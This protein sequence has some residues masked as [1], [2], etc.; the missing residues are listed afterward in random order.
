MQ[1]IARLGKGQKIADSFNRGK[2]FRQFSVSTMLTLV[3][4]KHHISHLCL[5]ASNLS[6]LSVLRLDLQTKIHQNSRP[7]ANRSSELE[8]RG[9]GTRSK[10]RLA[11]RKS[12]PKVRVKGPVSEKFFPLLFFFG[13]TGFW[14]APRA[15]RSHA[16]VCVLRLKLLNVRQASSFLA[17]LWSLGHLSFTLCERS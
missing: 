3:I 14:L 16:A 10:F 12:R 17:F 11:S 9:P 5:I 13:S 6:S 4:A 1:G 8:C 15:V 2:L 7:S